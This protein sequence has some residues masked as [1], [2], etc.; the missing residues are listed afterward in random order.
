MSKLPQLAC[1]DEQYHNIHVAVDK[2]RSTSTTVKVD[3]DALAALLRDHA[4][5][6][7]VA[8]RAA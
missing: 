6:I 8:R 5:L 3:R 2:T 7:E 1:S 4:K